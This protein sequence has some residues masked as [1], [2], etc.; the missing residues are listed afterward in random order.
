MGL[1]PRRRAWRRPALCTGRWL[2]MRSITGKT[3]PV[4]ENHPKGIVASDYGA[5][6][7]S[8][9]DNQVIFKESAMMLEINSDLL[10][11]PSTSH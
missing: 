7:V 1:W 8:A 10:K 11:Q 9:N 5:K 4:S 6:L 2:P 3:G